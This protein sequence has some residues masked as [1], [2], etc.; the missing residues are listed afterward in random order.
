MKTRL[1][2]LIDS[3]LTR[4]ILIVG[5]LAALPG[6]SGSLAV[7][8][9]APTAGKLE[10]VTTPTAQPPADTTPAV[11]EPAESQP[12]GLQPKLTSVDP[13]QL[14]GQWKDTFFGTR[15]LTLHADGTAQMTLDLDFA[16]RLMYGKRLEFDMQW[17]VE[18]AV[19]TIDI[20][21][22]RPAKS[23]KS[24]MNTWGNRYVYLLDCVED[25]QVEMRDS[26]GSMNHVLRRVE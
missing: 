4:G 10:Q 14:V 21:D 17:S 1:V 25:H 22:G 3:R 13:A 7:E 26:D 12:A 19:V 16:G 8:S 5:W 23:A 20:L 6:C 2:L 9:P 11:E 15:T 18:G 24:A